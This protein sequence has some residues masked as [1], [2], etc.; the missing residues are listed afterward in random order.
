MSKIIRE[1]RVGGVAQV[2]EHLPRKCEALSSNPSTEK[3][4]KAIMKEKW[5]LNKKDKLSRNKFN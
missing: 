5:P 3:R 2:G 4:K 1:E